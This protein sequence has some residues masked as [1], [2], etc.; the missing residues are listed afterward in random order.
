MT[1]VKLF[2]DESGNSGSDIYDLNQ[3]ILGYAGIWLSPEN[4]QRL[5]EFLG[6]LPRAFNIQ[7]VGE[8]KG[9]TLL[10]SVR[11]RQA[12]RAVLEYLRRDQILIAIVVVH[13]PYFAA[14]VLVDDCTDSVYNPRFDARW[15]SDPQL[16]GPLAER[17]LKTADPRQLEAAWRARDGDDKDAFK[18]A[19][20]SL[21][22]RLSLSLDRAFAE[23]AADMRKVDLED[24]WN[25][26]A[27]TRSRGHGYSPN[28]SGFNALIQESD[29]QA[30][31]LGYENVAVVHDKQSEFQQAFTE[32]F[33]MLR[34]SQPFEVSYSNGNRQRLPLRR[35]TNLSFVDSE[36][37]VGIQVADIVASTVRVG[38]QEFTTK[39]GSKSAEFMVALKA[40]CRTRKLLG[41][42]PFVIGPE[43]WQTDVWN[44][45]APM[46]SWM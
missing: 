30:E 41:E 34:Q 20:D 9:R 7:T 37:E 6:Q 27:S 46:G 39:Q 33:A 18:A 8:L 2:V 35:L 15:T 32:W 38:V 29:I 14:G 25:S 22:L 23:L 21:L 12:M 36:T 16:T 40:I 5:K 43:S 3:P 42:T 11:G 44:M 17:I 10:K 4:E 24:V 31:K 19:Y 28:Q 45:L 1:D 26:S 13:K